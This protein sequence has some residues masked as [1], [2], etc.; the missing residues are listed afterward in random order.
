MNH[1]RSDEQLAQDLFASV[2]VPFVPVVD[3]LDR[4]HRFRTRRRRLRSATV[5]SAVVLAV[6]LGWMLAPP[7]GDDVPVPADRA[8]D[9]P[10][11]ATIDTPTETPSTENEEEQ[12]TDHQSVRDA[13]ADLLGAERV[14]EVPE[15]TVWDNRTRTIDGLPRSWGMELPW[16]EA[17]QDGRG[18]LLVDFYPTSTPLTCEALFGEIADRPSCV[19]LEDALPDGVLEA[20][21]VTEQSASAPMPRSVAVRRTDGT[22]LRLRISSFLA[23]SGFDPITSFTLE[24]SD[25]LAIS[26]DERLRPPAPF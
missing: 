24:E 26:G 12:A 19:P 23:F 22:V 1:P 18:S 11:D 10:T 5:A 7:G 25:L 6:G 4:V 8:T 17:D 20:V 21:V 9:A 13:L 3:D 16:A 2:P 15:T 14:G